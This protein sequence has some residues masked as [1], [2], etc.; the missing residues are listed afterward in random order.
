MSRRGKVLS[1]MTWRVKL[2]RQGSSVA[3]LAGWQVAGG[4]EEKPDIRTSQDSMPAP[5]FQDNVYTHISHMYISR[6]TSIG[7]IT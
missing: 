5:S 4:Q 6:H 2:F 3:W 1:G 7:E